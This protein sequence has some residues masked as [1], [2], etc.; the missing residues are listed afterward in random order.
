[1]R[2]RGNPL[3]GVSKL[4]ERAESWHDSGLLTNF[5]TASTVVAA[6]LVVRTISTFTSELKD[7]SGQAGSGTRPR[8]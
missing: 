4:M 6:L 7:T 2:R 1:M 8:M 5:E 3:E